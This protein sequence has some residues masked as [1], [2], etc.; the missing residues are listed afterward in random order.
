LAL[1]AAALASAVAGGLFGHPAMRAFGSV[2]A[3]IVLG[4]YVWSSGRR[5]LLLAGLLVLAGSLWMP[6]MEAPDADRWTAV[7]ALIGGALLGA[8]AVVSGR[9]L[10]ASA[11]SA[12]FV[13][14]LPIAVVLAVMGLWPV[15]ARALFG[16]ASVAVVALAVALL[17]GVSC[18][19][20][21]VRRRGRTVPVAAVLL[22]LGLLAFVMP[23]WSAVGTLSTRPDV[24]TG[25]FL[26]PGLR[27]GVGIAPGERPAVD[28]T[29]RVRPGVDL[30]P[31]VQSAV[32]IASGERPAVTTDHGTSGHP[33]GV[34]GAVDAALPILAAA[35]LVAGSLLVGAA[36]SRR[37]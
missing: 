20:V 25:A 19:V 22:V 11:Y 23:L 1:F 27:H 13:G 7:A 37:D 12:V 31:G 30:T 8:A 5:P 32:A 9:H 14:L 4:V 15:F 3:V 21:L 29:P 10:P 6:V 26:E 2:A 35:M 36:A 28:L 24:A 16:S 18:G 17:A 33:P 34:G